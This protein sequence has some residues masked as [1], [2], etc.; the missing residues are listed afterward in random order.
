MAQEYVGAS[1]MAGNHQDADKSVLPTL[2]GIYFLSYC[3]NTAEVELIG[4]FEGKSQLPRAADEALGY[5]ADICSAVLK[6]SIE[7]NTPVDLLWDIFSVRR[8]GDVATVANSI[9]VNAGGAII[10]VRAQDNPLKELQAVALDLYPLFLI[11]PSGSFP[12]A[13]VSATRSF[14]V[15]SFDRYSHGPD[16]SRCGA[17]KSL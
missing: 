1:G 10:A 14:A 7:H 5:L 13:H 4:Y 17:A 9:R 11:P 16:P 12:I 3:T 8:E 6:Q 15:A 2:L